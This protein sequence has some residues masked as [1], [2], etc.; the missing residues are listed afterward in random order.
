LNF[1]ITRIEGDCGREL[2]QSLSTEMHTQLLG[3]AG[4]FCVDHFFFTQSCH[5]FRKIVL[6]LGFEVLEAMQAPL[7]VVGLLVVFFL[8]L[9][10][11]TV[12]LLEIL[13]CVFQ[14]RLDCC[15]GLF[16]ALKSPGFRRQVVTGEIKLEEGNS[17]R[18]VD[19]CLMKQ[20]EIGLG[21][22]AVALGRTAFAQLGSQLGECEIQAFEQLDLLGQSLGGLAVEI[23][24][25]LLMS[26]CGLSEFLLDF[27]LPC[28]QRSFG[29]FFGGGR[30]GA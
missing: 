15:E 3:F 17:F 11:R 8:G 16:P 20:I 25:T 27:C 10:S 30:L 26:C 28:F 5:R 14:R 18:D 29:F 24:H 23:F 22:I 12:A 13:I 7:G 6:Q 2:G 1:E 19:T 21:L 9:A 4:Q